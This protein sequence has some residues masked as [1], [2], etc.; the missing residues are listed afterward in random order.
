MLGTIHSVSSRTNYF[1]LQTY[2][3]H[4][5]L[6]R[7]PPRILFAFRI[8]PPGVRRPRDSS[9]V[10]TKSSPSTL[11]DLL[12]PKGRLTAHPTLQ[13]ANPHP[14]SVAALLFHVQVRV[15]RAWRKCGDGLESDSRE[16]GW[17]VSARPCRSP[18][19]IGNQIGNQT[20]PS[21]RQRRPQGEA[22]GSRARRSAPQ[23][24]R[25][26]A[27]GGRRGA[28]SRAPSAP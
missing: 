27:A 11:D 13:R 2:T 28:Q 25:R 26:S 12:S 17:R 21:K 10:Q 8:L 3:S 20:I 18:W 4:R 22:Q 7:G 6:A 5:R 1:A 14:V 24:A 19:Q 15:H 23:A 9:R 16:L